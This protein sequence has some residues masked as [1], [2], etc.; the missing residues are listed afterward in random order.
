MDFTCE[1]RSAQDQP[2]SS[3]SN[4]GCATTIAAA[5]SCTH[6]HQPETSARHIS[7]QAGRPSQQPVSQSI[8]TATSI[9][10]APKTAETSAIRVS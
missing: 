2:S 8:S 7:Q 5:T 6:T 10:I 1:F 9:I 4:C 3:I